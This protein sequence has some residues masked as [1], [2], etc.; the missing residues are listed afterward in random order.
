MLF[1]S[2]RRKPAASDRNV[3]IP[4][5]RL[6]N[7]KEPVELLAAREDTFVSWFWIVTGAFATTAP[8]ASVTIPEIEPRSSWA[9]RPPQRAKPRKR[10]EAIRITV[11]LQDT[12]WCEY[13]GLRV[14]MSI[15]AGVA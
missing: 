6:K 11:D 14:R 13:S 9:M 3:Y 15:V 12:S 5:G 4:T 10:G 1:T 2:W 7:A 8:V